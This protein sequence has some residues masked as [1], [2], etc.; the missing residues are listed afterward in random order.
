MNSTAIICEYNPF[1][2]AH[3][4]Q[5]KKLKSLYS[6]TCAVCIM[7]PNF[8]QRGVPALFDKYTR[9]RTAV[10]GGAD[11]VLSLPFV[12]SILSAQG[13]A[14]AGVDIAN[15]LGVD[16]L[17]FGAEDDDE[18]LLFEIASACLEKSFGEEL[19]D[20]CKTTPSLSL[21]RAGEEIIKKRLGEK[22]S[23]V[24][25]KPN[26]IL[27][28]EYIKSIIITNSKIKPIIIKRIGEGYKSLT[29][30]HF[31]SATYIREHIDAGKSLSGYV[32]DVCEKIYLDEIEKG[33]IADSKKFKTLLHSNLL[34]KSSD[35]LEI[36][37]GSSEIADRLF[38]NL[39]ECADFDQAVSK[40]VTSRITRTRIMRGALCSLF[41]IP[42]NAFMN[43]PPEYTQL[44]CTGEAGR[45]FL[46]EIRRRE[47][48]PV[49]TKNADYKKWEAN[50][51]FSMQ[52]SK[53]IEADRI[54][55]LLKKSPSA[56]NTFLK[57]SPSAEK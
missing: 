17:C 31:S 22:A 29:P 28:L 56:P 4:Y 49:I 47:H 36:Y 23:L 42:H 33:N 39:N 9:A 53:E 44:L 21:Q 45:K 12:F 18:K 48:L 2:N 19:L 20:L 15:S 38:K 3:E 46:S 11:L 35:E 24:L 30:S 40:T 57:I 32:P 37:F 1:H 10:L 25:N 50:P 13:F 43:A 41:E 34:L 8:V 51:E 5:I 54:W 6:E 27:A 7:S 26:N 16:S 55:A 52:F 14:R